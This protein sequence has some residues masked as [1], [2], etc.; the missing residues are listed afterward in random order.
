MR[1]RAH[2]QTHARMHARI[3]KND[4]TKGTQLHA[5]RQGTESPEKN[6]RVLRADLNG[7]KKKKSVG[8]SGV[9]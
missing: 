4:E 7:A 6:R 2:T 3:H 9:D 1:A 5:H 8:K